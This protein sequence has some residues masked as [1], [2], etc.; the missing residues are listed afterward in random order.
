MTLILTQRHR[1]S[2]DTPLISPAAITEAGIGAK[3]LVNFKKFVAP[4]RSEE[5][6]DFFFF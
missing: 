2:L 5:V 4:K 6:E 1:W 3:F